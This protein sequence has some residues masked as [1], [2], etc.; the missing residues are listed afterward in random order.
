VAQPNHAALAAPLPCCRVAAPTMIPANGMGPA[1]AGLAC[2][3]GKVCGNNGICALDGRRQLAACAIDTSLHELLCSINQGMM[4]RFSEVDRKL[5]VLLQ[6][7]QQPREPPQ[8]QQRNREEGGSSARAKGLL[9]TPPMQ[10]QPV[11]QAWVNDFDH[12]SRGS[13]NRSVTNARNRLGEVEEARPSTGPRCTSSLSRSGDSGL[14][15]V[16]DFSG[17]LPSEE[18]RTPMWRSEQKRDEENDVPSSDQEFSTEH[19][20]PPRPPSGPEF[21]VVRELP[22]GA[23]FMLSRSK[24]ENSG[25][26]TVDGSWSNVR[27]SFKRRSATESLSQFLPVILLRRGRLSEVGQ[28]IW[29]FFEEPDSSCAS[30]WFHRTWDPFIMATIAVTAVQTIEDPPIPGLT[31]A[32]LETSFDVIFTLEVILRYFSCSTSCVFIKNLHNIIDLFAAVPPL[33]M[34]ATMGFVMSEDHAENTSIH[35]LL[36]CVVPI[37]RVMKTLRR[38]QKFHLFVILFQ[39]IMEALRVLIFTLMILVLTASALIYLCEPRDNIESLPKAMWLTIVTVTTVGYGDKTP[40]ST[41]GHLV[42]SLLVVSS[43]LY[44]AMPIGIIGNAFTQI[45]QDRDRILLMIKTRDRLVQWGYTARD[46]IKLFR[47]FNTDGDGSLSLMEFRKMMSEMEIGL[48]EERVVELFDSIDKDNS[49]GIDVKEFIQGLFPSAYHEIY[50]AKKARK[51]SKD[52]SGDDSED[53]HGSK[54]SGTTHRRSLFQ[55]SGSSL[56]LKGRIM[57]RRAQRDVD[58]ELQELES[59]ALPEGNQS[60]LMPFRRNSRSNSTKS[61]GSNR[62]NYVGRASS[63]GMMMFDQGGNNNVSKAGQHHEEEPQ[64]PGMLSIVDEHDSKDKKA[65]NGV[66]L[67]GGMHLAVRELPPSIPELSCSVLPSAVQD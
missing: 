7:Q 16:G 65:E 51:E 4:A 27:N 11:Q 54:G 30:L 44:M 29:R 33:V 35:M 58:E 38:F 2:L 59:E 25:L 26:S 32:I 14:E 34:R 17:V 52:D 13:S 36:L 43:V 66:A 56:S 6:Q 22:V 46:M 40:Q 15:V 18:V 41:W 50:G 37:L 31:S 64:A 67:N 5:D 45:W 12:V 57:M 1:A 55:R 9:K 10:Q 53:R 62:P 21:P 28:K 47:H 42:V 23:P 8:L 63:R 39:T 60:Q 24:T 20:Q 61:N 19:S 3:D 48:S 49:G